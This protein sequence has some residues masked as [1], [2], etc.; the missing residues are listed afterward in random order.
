MWFSVPDI[1]F[2]MKDLTAHFGDLAWTSD[3]FATATQY[4]VE[5]IFYVQR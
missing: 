5:T 4:G 3:T 2:C 1:S